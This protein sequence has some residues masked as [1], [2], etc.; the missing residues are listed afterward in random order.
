M[1]T[2]ENPSKDTSKKPP[3]GR[4]KGPNLSSFDKIKTYFWYNRIKTKITVLLIKE[5][6]EEIQKLK[7]NTYSSLSNTEKKSRLKTLRKSLTILANTE[8]GKTRGAN[9]A[10][11]FKGLSNLVEQKGIVELLPDPV[12]GIGLPSEK[13]WA[14]YRA[15]ENK[16]ERVLDKLDLILP[17]TKKSYYDGPYRLF[18]IINAPD[19]TEALE[20]FEMQF[21]EILKKKKEQKMKSSHSSKIFDEPS[22]FIQKIEDARGMIKVGNMQ[23]NL[24]SASERHKYYCDTF[25]E[26]QDSIS[27]DDYYNL[28]EENEYKRNI[29]AHA[30]SF[31]HFSTLQAACLYLSL[32]FIA[33]R[34]LHDYDF[35]D[36]VVFGMRM[37]DVIEHC[38]EIP[39]KTW[40]DENKENEHIV[41]T[42]FIEM[43]S[44]I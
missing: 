23:R 40:F 30:S 12:H 14:R 9:A 26:M 39:A 17:G 4:P 6:L 43:Q 33:A 22:F 27:I 38:C 19:I 34:F 41:I 32:A 18:R 37:L 28:S 42:E 31:A 2:N 21:K 11:I 35:L 10:Q 20:L 7:G 24:T 15:A 44:R 25:L 29:F 1:T 16:P 5:H 13:S 36:R 8:V 3:K